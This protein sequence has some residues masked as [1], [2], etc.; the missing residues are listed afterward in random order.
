MVEIKKTEKYSNK[1]E[2]YK[3]TY[4]WV[5][6]CLCKSVIIDAFASIS[7]AKAVLNKVKQRNYN[8]IL[9]IHNELN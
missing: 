9:A 5:Y 3:E 6:M 8:N 1:K 4:T 7:D 2:A